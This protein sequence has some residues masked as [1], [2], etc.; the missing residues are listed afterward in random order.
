MSYVT[1]IGYA[2]ADP[3]FRARGGYRDKFTSFQLF[4]LIKS[5][6]LPQTRGM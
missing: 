6:E 1:G 5:Y 4:A 3:E 2:G